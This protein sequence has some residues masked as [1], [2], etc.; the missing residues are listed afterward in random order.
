M[1]Q[2][3]ALPSLVRHTRPVAKGVVMRMLE[4]LL[5]FPRE[6]QVGLPVG[7]VDHRRDDTGDES[8]MDWWPVMRSTL[9]R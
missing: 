4:V 9:S 5:A 3:V 8:L 6:T 7:Y 2:A 1:V